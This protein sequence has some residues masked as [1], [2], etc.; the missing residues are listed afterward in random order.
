MLLTRRRCSPCDDGGRSDELVAK[1]ED[2]LRARHEATAR[3]PLHRAD[4]AGA[5]AGMNDDGNDDT[6]GS[7]RM[8]TRLRR[9]CA[10]ESR[11]RQPHA[12]RAEGT[13]T[14]R[15]GREREAT[16]GHT[17][18]S[19]RTRAR[20]R[21]EGTRTGRAGAQPGREQRVALTCAPGEPRRPRESHGAG[22]AGHAGSRA[23]AAPTSCTVESCT[24][25]VQAA[26]RGELGLHGRAARNREDR[27]DVV[28]A[29]ER[30]EQGH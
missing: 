2:V 21:A 11:A 15:T 24:T 10:S 26:H 1:H 9:A 3:L 29:Q 17:H 6:P 28:A 18:G 8:R 5:A 22:H 25:A 7:R 4:Y 12:G 23:T 30:E 27:R 16:L 13:R 20:G 14:G 19:R